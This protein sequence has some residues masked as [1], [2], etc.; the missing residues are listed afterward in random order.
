MTINQPE[1]W[2]VGFDSITPGETFYIYGKNLTLDGERAY[3]Y[4]KELNVWL[5]NSVSSNPYKAGFTMPAT[6]VAGTYTIYAHNGHGKRYGWSD[7]LSITVQNDDT[8]NSS[9]INVTDY[10]AN[11]FDEADDSA[12]FSSA[13]SKVPT[14]GIL[15]IPDGTYYLSTRFLV[16]K[17]IRVRGE[18]SD[19]VLVGM[20]SAVNPVVGT[21]ASGIIYENLTVKNSFRGQ[22]LGLY[23]RSRVKLVNVVISSYPSTGERSQLMTIEK[24]HNILFE[25]CTFIV[26]PLINVVNESSNIRFDGCRFLGVYDCNQMM[27]VN[28]MKIDFSNCRATNLDASDA[29]SGDGWAKGRWVVHDAADYLYY[30]NNVVSNMAPRDPIPFFTTGVITGFSE[31]GEATTV[32]SMGSCKP[33]TFYFDDI[34]DEFDGRGDNS[35]DYSGV[36]VSV[37]YGTGESSLTGWVKENNAIDNYVTVWIKEDSWSK[38]EQM[39]SSVTTSA[40]FIDKIDQNSGEQILCEGFQAKQAGHVLGA[41]ATSLLISPVEA[42]GYSVA[43]KTRQ[44]FITGGRG[45]GQCRNVVSIDADTGEVILEKPWRVVPDSSST[46]E[47]AAGS[48]SFAVYGNYFSGRES[49]LGYTHRATTALQTTA[50]FGLVFEKNTLETMRHAARLYGYCGEGDALTG[51]NAPGASYFWFVNGNT[52]S[53]TALGFRADV[54]A[55]RGNYPLAVGESWNLGNVFRSNTVSG[56]TYKSAFGFYDSYAANS[57]FGINVLDA[58]QGEDFRYVISHIS[59]PP[60]RAVPVILDEYASDLVMVGN[61]FK[62]NADITGLSNTNVVLQQN[63]WSGFGATYGA[64]YSKLAVSQPVSIDGSFKIWNVGTVDLE[65]S[66]PIFGQGTIAPESSITMTDLED[67]VYSIES[68]GGSR[69]IVIANL[70][71]T[72]V[73]SWIKIPVSGYDGQWVKVEV[74]DV[75]QDITTSQGPWYE[76]SQLLIDT[77]TNRYVIRL[78]TSGSENGVYVPEK[79]FFEV[80]RD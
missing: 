65:W 4:V 43:S 21:G 22:A 69:N 19:A 41:T 48:M 20:T 55:N 13:L 58:N 59:Q 78:M 25:G 28:A 49:G 18:S 74:Q 24:C 3:C 23:N 7:P 64:G 67:G 12:A 6:A 27:T 8:W 10:G 14:G 38:A 44:A 52:V 76:P 9:V 80:P 36:L 66:S 34:P 73:G 30:G 26:T 2:W 32:W 77:P 54:F 79:D 75:V 53:E 39:N 51:M 29:G 50:S 37:P 33:V 16:S 45:L 40:E 46:Y 71:Q 35:V 57:T 63:T 62:G 47:L 31:L 15:Y 1:A 61:N 17:R 11:G 60:H 72:S 68:G 56:V 70:I 5:T 42:S